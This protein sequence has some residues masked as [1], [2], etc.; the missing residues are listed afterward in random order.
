MTLEF[1]MTISKNN[2]MNYCRRVLY[3][4]GRT[5][6]HAIN[7]STMARS[8]GEKLKA[9]IGDKYLNPYGFLKETEFEEY[10]GVGI[11]KNEFEEAALQNKRQEPEDKVN[12]NQA[13]SASVVS[14][15]NNGAN[16]YGFK[17]KGLEPTRFGDWER[18]GRCFD[19]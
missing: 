14:P 19:F 1:V 11:K 2:K 8:F 5:K 10:E 6:D 12:T 7:H 9:D 16:E 4:L 15:E 3:R 17:V 13:N 18:K